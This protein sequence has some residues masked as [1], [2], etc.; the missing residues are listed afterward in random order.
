MHITAAL[1]PDQKTVHHLL[2]I[3][4]N[5]SKL[6]LGDTNFLSSIKRLFCSTPLEC[7][8]VSSLICSAANS[9]LLRLEL[10]TIRAVKPTKT[11]KFQAVHPQQ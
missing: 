4:I 1:T 2:T 3:L 9:L 6:L 7:V 10:T 11:L 8:A 5:G